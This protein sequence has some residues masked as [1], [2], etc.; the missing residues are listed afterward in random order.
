MRTGRVGSDGSIRFPVR[1]HLILVRFP[2]GYMNDMVHCFVLDYVEKSDVLSS[3]LRDCILI[4]V[5]L[6]ASRSSQDPSPG[7]IH[8]AFT[9]VCL[10]H[11]PA[12]RAWVILIFYRPCS[13]LCPIK[14]APIV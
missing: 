10:L 11:R 5:P 4:S 8:S 14:R 2:D 1:S 3:S 7:L 12:S 9:D 6:V 13:F